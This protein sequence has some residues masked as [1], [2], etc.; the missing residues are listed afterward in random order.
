MILLTMKA[1][2]MDLLALRVSPHHEVGI[3]N[4]KVE[5]PL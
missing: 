1:R 2:M 4:L 5:E 3:N